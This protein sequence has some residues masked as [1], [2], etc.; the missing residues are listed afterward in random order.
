M[1]SEETSQES[2]S[3]PTEP[4]VEPATMSADP[5]KW[6]E[7]SRTISYRPVPQRDR[8]L[9]GWCGQCTLMPRRQTAWVSGTPGR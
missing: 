1:S 4:D 2:T 3:S 9:S 5:P 7:M 8:R 6:P